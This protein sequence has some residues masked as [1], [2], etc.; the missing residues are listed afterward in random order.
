MTLEGDG[1]LRKVPRHLGTC[2]TGW[3]RYTIVSSD[4]VEGS[5]PGERLLRASPGGL[6]NRGATDE[7][8]GGLAAKWARFAGDRSDGLST[9]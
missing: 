9:P 4:G 7:P 1:C 3:K 2:P 6:S 8:V 5:E